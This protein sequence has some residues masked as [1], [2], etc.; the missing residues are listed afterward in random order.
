VFIVKNDSARSVPVE[1]GI[2]TEREV[3]ITKGLNPS[4]T[5]I[6]TGLLQVKDKGKVKV[7]EI[8]NK[9]TLRVTAQTN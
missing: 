8:V 9:E 5:I 1:T 4:D 7:E 2:R 3:Q 6:I